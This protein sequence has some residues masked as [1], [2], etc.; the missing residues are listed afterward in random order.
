MSPQT[1]DYDVDVTQSWLSTNRLRTTPAILRTWSVVITFLLLLAALLAFVAARQFVAGAEQIEQNTGPVL[2]STQGLVASLAEADAA[3]TAVFLSG[4]N[5]DR[6]Q[7]SL[8]ETALSRA[9]QQI[10]DISSGIGNDTASHDS[11]KEVA[12]Q[13]TEYAGLVERARLG[14]LAGSADATSDLQASIELV[15]GPNGMLANAQLV[16]DRTQATFD[17]DVSSGTIEW[18]G[19]VGVLVVAILVLVVAQGRLK[20]RTNRLVNPALLLATVCVV[21]L[22]I[23][24]VLA[25]IGRVSDL[26]VAR[27]NGYDSIALTAE[28][29]TAAFDYKTQEARAIIQGSASALPGDESLTSIDSLLAELAA[30]ADNERE[31]SAIEGLRTRWNRYVATSDTIRASLTAG[32]TDGARATAIGNGNTDFNGFNTTVESVL[33]ANRDQFNASVSSA[34]N[35][36]RWLQLGALMLPLIAAVLALAGYQTRINEYW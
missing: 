18:A 35:R 21:G 27:E 7:R 28:L 16:T 1:G 4:E 25:Q 19:A 20:K 29:Q 2:I 32:D 9:P 11:L 12:S 33:L 31:V 8:Y 6:Q 17:D 14:N 13:L 15:S 3:N 36:L 34:T 10:E 22:L 23:W 24:L 26:D 5:E 30:E